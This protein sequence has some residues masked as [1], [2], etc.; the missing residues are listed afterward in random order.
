M[1]KPYAS[2]KR[3]LLWLACLSLTSVLTACGT[4]DGGYYDRNGNWIA[5]NTP[6]N[7]EGGKHPPLPGGTYNPAYYDDDYMYDRRGYYD[8]NGYYVTDIRGTVVPES[9]FPPR[10]M[11]RVW[12]TNRVPADQPAVESCVGIR[13]R[14]PAG[15]YVIYGG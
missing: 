2:S 1:K 5:T 13:S 4:P 15:A 6:R 10:G 3:G 12:F 14:V 7:M 8:V 9:M 11:C